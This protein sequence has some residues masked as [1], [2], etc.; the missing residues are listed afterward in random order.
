MSFTHILRPTYWFCNVISVSPFGVR[1]VPPNL[2]T[3]YNII[4]F[5]SIVYTLVV[6]ARYL[7]DT[8]VDKYM[9]VVLLCSY[10]VWYVFYRLIFL[11]ILITAIFYHKEIENIRLK[12]I[13]VCHKL[14]EIGVNLNLKLIYSFQLGFIC[15]SLFI[16]LPVSYYDV[17]VTMQNI[18]QGIVIFISSFFSLTIPVLITA[19][20]F[21]VN[22][23]FKHVNSQLNNLLQHLDTTPTRDALNKLK[24]LISIH[25]DI[26]GIKHDI[27]SALHL[28]LFLYLAYSV[29]SLSI[30]IL[31]LIRSLSEYDFY[32]NTVSKFVA[33]KY[34]LL[35]LFITEICHRTAAEGNKTVLIVHRFFQSPLH[36][37]FMDEIEMFSMGMIDNYCKFTAGGWFAIDRS[38]FMKIVIAVTTY[39]VICLQINDGSNAETS[40]YPNATMFNFWNDTFNISFT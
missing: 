38:L 4:A 27:S 17:H 16:S 13:K 37:C 11:S 22:T 34:V 7:I 40:S 3:C 14:E 18:L 31:I 28:P 2:A 23:Q 33:F 8:I 29:I 20:S 19:Y 6:Y 35:I 36:H 5:F 12:I 10:I 24:Q 21:I 39:V 26:R 32:F 1:L 30:T 15:F 25:I 9:H